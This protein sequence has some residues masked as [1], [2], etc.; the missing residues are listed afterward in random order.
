MGCNGKANRMKSA[1]V[2]KYAMLIGRKQAAAIY[3]P[4]HARQQNRRGGYTMKRRL[5]LLLFVLSLLLCL[6]QSPAYAEIPPAGRTVVPEGVTEIDLRTALGD[7]VA[8]VEYA[9]MLNADICVLIRQPPGAG[10]SE[11]IVLDLRDNRFLSRT[12]V[13]RVM[14]Q[15][16]QGF[17][18][19]VFYLLLT[20]LDT[21]NYDIAFYYVKATVAPDGTVDI[22]TV[23]GGLIVMPGG[24]T[25][26]REA[27]DR[28][29]YAMDLATYRMERLIQGVAPMTLDWEG[30]SY[31]TF[32]KYVPC[33]DDI[34]CNELT[35]PIDEDTYY[36]NALFLWRDFYVYK[37]L[38]EYRFVYKVYGW[39][40]GAGYGIYDLKT[41]TDHRITGS[42]T[43]CG[44]VGNTLYGSA[45]KTDADTLESWP[46]P[47]SVQEQL[48]D[49]NDM[50]SEAEYGISPDGRLLAVTGTES[51]SSDT[52]TVTVTDL[53]TGR[54]IKAYDIYNPF[55]WESSVSFYGDT[56]LMLFFFPRE[57]GSAYMY[58]LNT[59][60]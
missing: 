41:H 48:E 19:G 29:L 1:G 58:L 28:S 32:L 30:A 24:K 22:T 36:E 46:L 5:V 44:M 26:I 3:A 37:P 38:D 23:P 10:E 33:P 42:G 2:A 8:D 54:V 49:A 25:A 34:G 15:P 45:L 35:F 40:W 7:G 43:L 14:N 20:P 39:E 55:A 56:H 11:L 17:E 60:E 13:P 9:W 4:K 47:V 6:F 31:D 18:N 52:N 59:A 50:G 57:H 27:A 21:E 51:W 16:E 53:D 12:P